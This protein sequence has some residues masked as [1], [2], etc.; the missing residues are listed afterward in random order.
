M[1]EGRNGGSVPIGGTLTDD[2]SGTASRPSGAVAGQGA[3]GTG[4]DLSL[5]ATGGGSVTV[6][7][8]RP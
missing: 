2:A 3:P 1:V 7:G 4:G 6:A 5:A 8:P